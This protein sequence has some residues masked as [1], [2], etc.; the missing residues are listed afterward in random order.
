MQLH[1]VKSPCMWFFTPQAGVLAMWP[2]Y[3]TG[4]PTYGQL[5][6]STVISMDETLERGTYEPTNP[7]Q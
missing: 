4:A 3:T 7:P 5:Q 1:M 2:W 6:Q